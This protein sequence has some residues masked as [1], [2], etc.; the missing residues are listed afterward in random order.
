MNTAM[1]QSPILKAAA[2]LAFSALALSACASSS[3][4]PTGAAAA[5]PTESMVA[6]ES[7]SPSESMV[8]KESA[9]PSVAAVPASLQFSGTALDGSTFAGA[10]LAGKPVV[11][12]F[13]APWC[14]VCRAEGPDLAALN[15]EYAGRVQFVGIPGLGAVDEMKG[16][17]SDTGTGGFLHVSDTDGSL[18]AK[19]GVPSQPS[20]VFVDAQG[21]AQTSVGGMNADELRTKIN[22][23]IG[24]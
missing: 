7:A 19:F 13:W 17:V 10:S 18:W 16:F 1:F 21:N 3:Q 23:L 9:S 22:A 6:K 2:A 5:S 12:W 8:A 20:F 15:T 4:S 14:S 11:M 24:A